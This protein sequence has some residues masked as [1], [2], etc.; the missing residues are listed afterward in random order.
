MIYSEN[1]ARTFN[2]YG[3]FNPTNNFYCRYL[4]QEYIEMMWNETVSEVRNEAF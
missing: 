4:E 2:M 1:Q 3:N